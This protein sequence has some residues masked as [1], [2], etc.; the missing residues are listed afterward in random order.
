VVIVKKM[1]KDVESVLYIHIKR[2]IE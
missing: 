2:L 1:Q